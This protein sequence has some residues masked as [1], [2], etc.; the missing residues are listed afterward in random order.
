MHVY[1]WQCRAGRQN[2]VILPDHKYHFDFDLSDR[3]HT[4]CASGVQI[5]DIK[6]HIRSAVIIYAALFVMVIAYLVSAT[7]NPFLYFRF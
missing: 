2:S 1:Y 3:I 5:G 6:K 7:Y 4:L